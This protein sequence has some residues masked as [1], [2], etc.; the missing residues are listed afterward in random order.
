MKL[1][2]VATLRQG[3][4]S[5]QP[6][7]VLVVQ[8]EV[9]QDGKTTYGIIGGGDIRAAAAEELDGIKPIVEKKPAK[10]KP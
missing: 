9:G 4:Q 8:A 3:K 6:L 5:K 1:P 7:Q 2:A 10:A